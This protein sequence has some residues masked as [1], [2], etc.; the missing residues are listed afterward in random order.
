MNGHPIFRR[1]KST[2]H[3]EG[4]RWPAVKRMTRALLVAAMVA[5]LGVVAV[6]SAGAVLPGSTFEG[7]DGR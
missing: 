7:N 4:P 5:A 2:S 1:G 6:N 3:R